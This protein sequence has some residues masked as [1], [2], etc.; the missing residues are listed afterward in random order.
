MRKQKPIKVKF[1]AKK[2]LKSLD[3]SH[4]VKRKQD[5]QGFD[6]TQNKEI[7]KE[8]KKLNARLDKLESKTTLK[9]LCSELGIFWTDD[10][11]KIKEWINKQYDKA[12]RKYKDL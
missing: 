9:D 6:I 4:K 10:P 8:L 5:R 12:E 1:N 2:T 7:L 3:Y 11:Q